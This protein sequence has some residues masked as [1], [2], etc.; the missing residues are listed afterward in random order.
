MLLSKI[1][2]LYKPTPELSNNWISRFVFLRLLGIVYFFA[3]FSLW[4]QI[5]GLLGSKGILPI[6][7][8]LNKLS[9]QAPFDHLLTAF[10]YKPSI[11]WLNSSNEFLSMTA[12][13]GV[14]LSLLITFG[15]ANAFLLS[16]LWLLYLSFVH[17]G[18]R[19][20]SFGWDILLCEVG[21]FAIFLAPLYQVSSFFKKSPPSL[22]PLW[23]LRWLAFR[24]MLGAGLIKLKAS[25]TCWW[26]LS[27]LENHYETQPIPNPISWYLHQLPV[28]F[29]HFSVMVNH[30]M[31]LIIPFFLIAPKKIRHFG[32][33]CTIIFQLLLIFSGNLSFLNWL[34]I[35]VCI[36]CLEDSFFLRFLSV[37]LKER[38]RNFIEAVKRETPQNLPVLTWKNVIQTLVMAL[39]IFLSFQPVMNLLSKTQ[40]M[41]SSYNQFFLVNTYGAFGSV[42]KTRQEIIIYGTDEDS[43]TPDT[44]WLEYEFYYKPGNL[45]KTPPIVAPYQPRLDWQIWFAAMSHYRN[46]PWFIVLIAKLLENEPVVTHLL[47]YNPFVDQAPKFI[48]ADLYQY[49]FTKFP[50][51]DAWWKRKKIGPYF[52][53]ISLEDKYLRKYLKANGYKVPSY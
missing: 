8:F 53:P 15:F 32:A 1:R 31:E 9:H 39:T 51:K 29:Q 20:Y 28:D 10:Y 23:C 16:T 41:N 11:F 33:A 4:L 2:D 38:Y 43:V 52:P 27:C 36:A 42:G 6:S 3:F 13:V 22:L 50:E 30:V 44:K 45:L 37:S 34:T 17:V 19:F 7:L 21:F 47:D 25:E 26:D 48:K 40:A 46:H 24:I 35:T 18:Q 5:P 49:E 14:L 12:F